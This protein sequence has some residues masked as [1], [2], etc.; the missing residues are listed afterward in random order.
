MKSV[1]SFIIP[2]Y[3]EG[4]TIKECI[5]SLLDMHYPSDRLD[6]VVVDS[7][8]TDD[9][10]SIIKEFKQ[11]RYF[12]D[13]T[14]NKPEARNKAVKES[15]GDFLFNYSG[16]VIADKELLN[17]ILSKFKD[18]IQAVGCPNH[19]SNQDKTGKT[20]GKL[21]QGFMAGGGTKTFTQNAMF[22]EDR[23]VEH[24]PFCCYTR[25]LFEEI[26]FFDP[27]LQFG[28]DAEYNLRVRKKGYKILYTPDTFV[29]HYKPTSFR[30]LFL[31]MYRYGV[32][33]SKILGKHPENKTIMYLLPNLIL[34]SGVVVLLLAFLGLIPLAIIP[35]GI[36]AY[37]SLCVTSSIKV[38]GLGC[39]APGIVVYPLIHS[40]YVL[41]M[42]KG[43]FEVKT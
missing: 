43:Y 11:V 10:I 2:T 37:L 3:N 29:D 26:G 17:V 15:K 5:E 22:K 9:T 27:D 32:A 25:E 20:I 41:G 31:K 23:F 12:V 19:T 38:G 40:G 39:I 6:I 42:I 8:S 13:K 16:H 21:F 7:G 18:G 1:V 35:V 24:I 36:S 34:S 4:K 33:R 30:G 28:Q 14:L